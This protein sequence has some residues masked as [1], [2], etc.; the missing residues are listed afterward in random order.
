[1]A[2]K[3]SVESYKA[4]KA[5]GKCVIVA[6]STC[7]FC[8]RAHQ[9][10]SE[11]VPEDKLVII[12]VDKTPEGKKIRAQAK[13]DGKGHS[14]LP[15]IFFGDNYIG[16]CDNISELKTR[17]VLPKHLGGKLLMSPAE[18]EKREAAKEVRAPIGLERLF[19]LFYFPHT[20]NGTAVR[21]RGLCVVSIC[22]MTIL[23]GI[24]EEYT[25]WTGWL[26]ILLSVDYLV[27]I[28]CG[29]AA[30]PLAAFG[31]CLTAC[32]PEKF[33]AGAPK[34]FAA[35]LGMMFSGIAG[36][37][38][39]AEWR[40]AGIIVSGMLCG[41]AGLETFL[42]FCAGCWMFGMMIQFKILPPTMHNMHIGQKLLV[43]M[44]ASR[45]D[46]FETKLKPLQDKNLQVRQIGQPA[47]KADNVIPYPKSE[48]HKRRDFNPIKHVALGDFIMPLSIL[49]LALAY[50]VAYYTPGVRCR[51][52]TGEGE[53]VLR[54]RRCALVESNL[55]WQ[56]IFYLS[57]VIFAGL[58]VLLVMKKIVYPKKFW[59]EIQH[60]IRSSGA[61]SL[62]AYL[63]LLAYMLFD[64]P[65]EVFALD[66]EHGNPD[67]EAWC[68]T[69]ACVLFWVGAILLKLLMI[70][71]LASMVALRG[72]KNLAQANMLFP[73]MACV[74]AA[75]VAPVFENYNGLG[76]AYREIGWFFF[77][78]AAVLAILMTGGTLMEAIT[79][80]WSDERIRP[81]VGLWVVA[82]HLP[83]LAYSFLSNTAGP[84]LMY[85]VTPRKNFYSTPDAPT[86]NIL[87]DGAFVQMDVI[88]HTLYF[89][90][91]SLFLVLA[92]LAFPMGFLLRLKFDFSFWQLA[93]P[94]DMLT[95]ATMV[96]LKALHGTVMG[97]GFINGLAYGFLALSTY[98]HCSLFFN[99]LF[100]LLKRR[101]LR[102]DYK[103]APLSI[104]ML[105]HEAFKFAG[106]GLLES[107]I[108]LKNKTDEA[109][110][111][112]AQHLAKEW[113]SYSVVLEWHA[114][115]EEKHM[116]P[117]I[118]GFN[119]FNTHNAHEQHL[120]LG[121]LEHTMNDAAKK[122]LTATSWGPAAK[123]AVD[124]LVSSLETYIPYFEKHLQW[125][126]ENLLVTNRRTFNL[127]IQIRI[128]QKIWAEYESKTVETFRAEAGLEVN[129]ESEPFLPGWKKDKDPNALLGYPMQH[130]PVLP[131][132][133]K[134][135]W[136]VV[137][138]WVIRHLALPMQRARFVKALIW[139]LPE[140]AQHI[141]EMIYRGVED[142]EWCAI[143]QDVPEIIPRGLPGWKRRV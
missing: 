5:D 49:A 31:N 119:P 110:L 136:R 23:A 108:G 72:D 103:W 73:L 102:P 88:Q 117:E 82:F 17:G 43:K 124:A 87:N 14:T 140:R 131:M 52:Q 66:S 105:T 38:L 44:Q 137:L 86:Y 139:A 10:L 7:A 32:L 9:L 92:F 99:T 125:E 28:C 94:L 54:D 29:G 47:T 59:S 36:A 104:N 134:Q 68:R 18:M 75:M 80:H 46:D 107:A 2:E 19:P 30:S 26:N 21:G 83:F 112:E 71:K 127:D 61:A 106:E 67:E 25:R 81:S 132:H 85:D 133:K 84:G 6:R 16:G 13:E 101:W 33:S 34:Q 70:Y 55:V 1:M 122:I 39:V 123:E 42:D 118:D 64:Y 24:I 51:W 116:F 129:E 4:A 74:I 130:V 11:Y 114:H 100:W 65:G 120:Y 3:G 90:G 98:V 15:V 115:Q 22:V 57:L 76:R 111:I 20:V 56:V 109:T 69:L 96:Y 126:E 138:P 78:L 45:A 50:Q 40:W 60:P 121:E 91:L 113:E 89:A 63:I 97:V 35:F 8:I 143:T 12:N 62:P 95:I 77:A 142:H 141:G 41:A 79:Y 48:D 37:F 27:I 53:T 135:V 58:F 128:V 93:F